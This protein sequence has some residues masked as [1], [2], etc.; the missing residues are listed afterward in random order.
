MTTGERLV[1]ISTLTTGTALQHFLNISTGTGGDTFIYVRATYS[2]KYMGDTDSLL[3]NYG[4]S[5]V[6]AVSYLQP[7][8]MALRYVEDM[9]CIKLS[10]IPE[11][12][13]P[14]EYIVAPTIP[15]TFVQKP[16]MNI[17]YIKPCDE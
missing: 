13:L 14:M 9:N 11:D 15:V 3:I 1:D 17:T 16:T 4:L 8:P 12:L 7:S 10:Y 2:V 6:V 5:D